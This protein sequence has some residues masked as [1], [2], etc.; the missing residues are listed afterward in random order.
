MDQPTDF[1]LL[2][3][4][5]KTQPKLFHLARKFLFDPVTTRTNSTAKRG[6]YRW[7]TTPARRQL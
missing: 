1:S 2:V 6:F 5:L 7:T 4:K 3:G